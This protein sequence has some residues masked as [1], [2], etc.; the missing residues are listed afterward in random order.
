MNKKIWML[1]GGFTG[2]LTGVYLYLLKKENKQTN[3]CIGLVKKNERIIKDYEQWMKL[4]KEGK[5]VADYLKEYYFETVAIYGLGY[6]GRTLL[7]EL[8]EEHIKVKYII[9]QNI[10]SIMSEIPCYKPDE[11]LPEVDAIIVT[12]VGAYDA[13][14]EKL[15][16]KVK[17]PIISLE[18]I[19][20]ELLFTQK[21]LVN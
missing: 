12:A 20:D 11:N 2:V 5:G 3:E 6:M 18:D 10:S 16:D 9:D 13:I 7:G 14:E 19:L 1:I 21:Q 17:C 4:R 15:L 8:E